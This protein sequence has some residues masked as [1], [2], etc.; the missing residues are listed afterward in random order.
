VLYCFF[1]IAHGRR[2]IFHFNVTSHPAAGWI[3]RILRYGFLRAVRKS[4]IVSKLWAWRKL[5]MPT[6]W[7]FPGIRRNRTG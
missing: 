1:I 5:C 2:R 6:E 3:I 4:K 7:K